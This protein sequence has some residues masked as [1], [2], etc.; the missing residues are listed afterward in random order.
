[1]RLSSRIR[2]SITGIDGGKGLPSDKQAEDV[3]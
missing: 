2:R 1:L 3:A